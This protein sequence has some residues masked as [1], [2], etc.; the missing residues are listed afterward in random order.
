MFKTLYCITG[1]LLDAGDCKKTEIK[2]LEV[3]QG[4]FYG[5]NVQ[6]LNTFE[7]KTFTK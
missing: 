6:K 5:T 2:K 1:C 3:G 4:T 7:S